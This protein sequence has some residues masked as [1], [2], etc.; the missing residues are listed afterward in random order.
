LS[1]QP[2]TRAT[3]ILG[4]ALGER[5]LKESGYK[6]LER[7]V[8]S[9]FGEID[10]VA[11]HA[12]T[13]VFVEVKSRRNSEYGVGEEAVTERKKRQLGRLAEWYL[14]RHRK[15]KKPVRFDV[16]AI[17]LDEPPRY[18]LIQNAIEF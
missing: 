16:L 13:I 12:K 10:L 6:I 5:F 3:G 18:R 9:S 2:S 17:E 4:E 1:A 15:M 8:R 14:S 7:N 11:E